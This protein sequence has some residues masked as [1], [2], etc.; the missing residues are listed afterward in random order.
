[1]HTQPIDFSGYAMISKHSGLPSGLRESQGCICES[2]LKFLGVFEGIRMEARF[3]GDVWIEFGGGVPE[4][5]DPR[6]IEGL[7]RAIG[8][9]LFV[10]ASICDGFATFFMDQFGDCYSLF[11]QLRRFLLPWRNKERDIF[12]LDGYPGRP[13]LPIRE[14]NQ[15]HGFETFRPR[16]WGVRWIESDYW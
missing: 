3:V 7:A 13:I 4:D 14:Y 12:I 15:T 16:A 9:G 10:V 1:M 11:H 2:A 5:V 6:L 8:V